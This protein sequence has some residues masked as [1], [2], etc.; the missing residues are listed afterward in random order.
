MSGFLT[1]DPSPLVDLSCLNRSP[2]SHRLT[3]LPLVRLTN[4]VSPKLRP[5]TYV[6]STPTS[7]RLSPV[8]SLG[9]NCCRLS[10]SWGPTFPFPLRPTT[11]KSPA[12][13]LRPSGDHR[14]HPRPGCLQYLTTDRTT[15][16]VPPSSSLWDRQ[17]NE[18]RRVVEGQGG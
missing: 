3:L 5:L 15:D 18:G 4:F 17:G 12:R 1:P 2:I 6:S 8:P 10:V 11:L 13:D 16:S 14:G 7:F 9:C